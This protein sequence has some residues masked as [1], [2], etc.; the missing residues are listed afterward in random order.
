MV[1][2]SMAAHGALLARAKAEQRTVGAVIDR[3][4]GVSGDVLE[5]SIRSTARQQ[6][7]VTGDRP[8][9]GQGDGRHTGGGKPPTVLSAN[10]HGLN[11]GERP[12]PA[13][14]EA[15]LLCRCGHPGVSHR[16]KCLMRGCRCLAYTEVR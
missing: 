15:V 10:I 3:W 12:V 8:A 16:P 6:Q 1:R 13:S 4:L 11:T 2:V 14:T 9:R 7:G 5:V